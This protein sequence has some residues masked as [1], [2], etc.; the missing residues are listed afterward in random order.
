MPNELTFFNS[1]AFP[2]NWNP[3][4]AFCMEFT[5]SLI[6]SIVPRLINESNRLS[7]Y[8]FYK[9]VMKSVLAVSLVLVGFN[10]SG[11]M[12]N[13]VVATVIVGRCRGHSYAEHIII[14]WFGATSGSLIGSI[15]YP[16]IK[17]SISGSKVVKKKTFS[18]SVQEIECSSYTHNDFTSGKCFIKYNLYL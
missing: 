4:L 5:G 1:C 7:N 17:E 8:P 13:P 18:P 2:D 11:G 12:Y 9:T 10:I 14:Y 15:F 6:L 3:Y 16:Q